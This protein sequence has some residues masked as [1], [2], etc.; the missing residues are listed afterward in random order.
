MSSIARRLLLAGALQ[1]LPM[2]AWAQSI[3][4]ADAPVGA[5]LNDFVAALTGQ[6]KAGRWEVVEDRTDTGGKALA[7]LGPDRTDYR[8][9][10]AI[11]E[12]TIPADVEVTIRFKPISGKVDKA[13]G[14]AVRLTDRNNYYLARANALEDNVTFYRVVAGKR[15]QIAG[16]KMKV[17]PGEWHS[18]TLRARGDA[19]TILF[20]GRQALTATDERFGA[21]GKVALWTKADSITHF[22]R[23]E[24][25][26]LE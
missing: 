16:A 3:T 21:P 13:G 23:L 19:F 9:P 25:T 12:P 15:Q 14:V 20:D 10:L 17:S 26:P 2:A 1:T 4:F 5:L 24:I 8:F 11:F 7:Q 18:L 6:G 22:D